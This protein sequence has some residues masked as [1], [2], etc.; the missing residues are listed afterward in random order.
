VAHPKTGTCWN[1]TYQDRS[2]IVT[3]IDHV[4][5]GY[6]LSEEAMDKLTCAGLLILLSL[7]F[8]DAYRSDNQAVWSGAVDGTGVQVAK[9]LCGLK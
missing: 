9:S 7:L 2:V 3:V 1:V 6:N 4:G 8:A 5:D